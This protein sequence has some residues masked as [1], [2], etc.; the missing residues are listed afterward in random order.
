MWGNKV[1]FAAGAA[2][3]QYHDCTWVGALAH[4]NAL[5]SAGGVQVSGGACGKALTLAEWQALDPAHD[6]GSTFNGTMPS[7]E[8]IVAWGEALLEPPPA[9]P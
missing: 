5:F 6:V 2:A 7:G 8:E 4:H 3:A 1:I 9:W